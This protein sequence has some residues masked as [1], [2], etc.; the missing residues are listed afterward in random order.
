KMP[1]KDIREIETA[2]MT[3]DGAII[4][5]ATLSEWENQGAVAVWNV[6]TGKLVQELEAPASEIAL[7]PD[8]KLLAVGEATGLVKVW[9]L[10]QKEPLAILANRGRV[11]S[12]AFNRNIRGAPH[13]RRKDDTAGWLLAV[14]TLVGTLTIWDLEAKQVHATCYG[15][16]YEIKALAFSPDGTT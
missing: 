10:T 6:G 1:G 2:V 5:A 12:L 11:T 16:N 8:G 15:S 13:V 9:S 4:A 14:G 3:P 7:S